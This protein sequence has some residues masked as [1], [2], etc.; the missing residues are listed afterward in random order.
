MFILQKKGV[1]ICLA[2]HQIRDSSFPVA[3]E[4]PDAFGG[5]CLVCVHIHLCNL[6]FPCKIELYT[7]MAIFGN[8]LI[9]C[10]TLD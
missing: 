3:S 1:D 5:T 9:P 4:T 2:V 6:A 7:I 10:L 8:T